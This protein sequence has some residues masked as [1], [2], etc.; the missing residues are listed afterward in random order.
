MP[1]S[2]PGIS[3][4]ER[5]HVVVKANIN[6]HATADAKTKK[7]ERKEKQEIHSAEHYEEELK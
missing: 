5:L 7:M 6:M 1:K 3:S 4:S 2:K